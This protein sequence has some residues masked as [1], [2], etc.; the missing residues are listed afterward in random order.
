MKQN[1]VKLEDKKN[2]PNAVEINAGL[3]SLIIQQPNSH[4]FGTDF[5]PR[6][7]LW[8]YNQKWAYYEKNN[9]DSLLKKKKVEAPVL[10]D[11]GLVHLSKDAM[12]MYMA[13]NGFLFSKVEDTIFTL[14]NKEVKVLYKIEAGR[15]FYIRKIIYDV[16]DETVMQIIEES[17]NEQI[18]KEGAVFKKIDVGSERERLYKLLRSKGYYALKTENIWSELDTSNVKAFQSAFELPIDVTTPNPDLNEATDSI[19]VILKFDPTRDTSYLEKHQIRN[20]KISFKNGFGIGD[21]SYL[22]KDTF[23]SFILHYNTLPVNV[24]LL[25]NNIFIKPNSFYS[26]T[27]EQDTYNRLNQIGTFQFVNIEFK[28]DSLSNNI[29]DCNI[30]LVMMKRRDIT[31]TS[32]LNSS[33]EYFLG[34]SVG[35]NYGTKNLWKGANRLNLNFLTSVQTRKT[36]DVQLPTGLILYSNNFSTALK[37]TMPKFFLPVKFTNSLN[38][39]PF[40]TMSLSYTFINRVGSY[41]L[42]NSV[43]SLGYNWHE[44]AN[45]SWLVNPI[46]LS[47]THVPTKYLSETFKKQIESSSILI[48]TYSNNFIQGENLSYEIQS[49]ATK[50]QKKLHAVRFGLEEAGTLMQ[51]LNTF[52]KSAFKDSISAVSHY[53]KGDVNYTYY[54]N[55]RKYRWVSH[56]GLGFGMPTYGDKSLPYIKQYSQGGSFSNRGW[57]LRNLGP[58][59][60][61]ID[62][63]GG[64]NIVDRTGDMKLELNTEVRFKIAPIMGG[65]FNLDGAVFTDAGNIWLYQGDSTTVDGV[66]SPKYFWQDIAISSGLGF[67]LDFSFF[68]FRIDYAWKLKHPY[69]PQNSGWALDEIRLRNGQWNFALGYPF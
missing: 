59:R 37:L 50:S 68:V 69:Y 41:R 27:K 9:S 48:N 55:H 42:S 54:Y 3:N 5:L 18:L 30:E 1:E 62:T 34:T 28:K 51:G 64:R 36:P 26:S 21:E 24:A 35:F 63:T 2:V 8:K 13:N 19:T 23:P 60:Q 33:G 39:K 66:F 52:L 25:E 7:R 61:M 56:V 22:H 31:L 14:K 15:K 38:N 20:V 47:F 10:L 11:T 44:A 32:D 57:Q 29:V 58:G 53:L 17:K 6:Y 4:V 49:D 67:R 16:K 40:T 45:K 65:T 46:F 43:A 12:K